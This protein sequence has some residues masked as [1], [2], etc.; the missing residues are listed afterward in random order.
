MVSDWMENGTINEFIER[1]KDANRIGL[2]G[3]R[4]IPAPQKLTRH[5]PSSSTLRRV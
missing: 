1:N 3:F 4:I 5:L 2:V